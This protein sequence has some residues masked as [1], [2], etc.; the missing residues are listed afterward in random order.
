VKT[1][2]DEYGA[3]FAKGIRSDA[4]LETVRERTGHS[5]SQLVKDISKN[6]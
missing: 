5:L 2:R 1:L 3:G 4:K 6:K